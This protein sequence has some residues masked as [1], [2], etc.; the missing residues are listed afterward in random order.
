SASGAPS[1]T[2]QPDD[3]PRHTFKLLVPPTHM[4]Y[5]GFVGVATGAGAIFVEKQ[6]RDGTSGVETITELINPT[7][8][9]GLGSL[10]VDGSEVAYVTMWLGSTSPGDDAQVA[11]V[12]ST[13][14]ELPYWETPDLASGGWWTE[15]MGHS[16]LEFGDGA[17]VET[18]EVA[19]QGG[20]GRYLK[21]MSTSLVE[22]GAWR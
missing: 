15:G 20:R 7:S 12:A 10:T 5:L 11:L 1:A 16:G 17:F 14:V 3:R 9:D 22:V 4:L 2:R 18:Y 8:G 13:A 19:V 6:F 21:G